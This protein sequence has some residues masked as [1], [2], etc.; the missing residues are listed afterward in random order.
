MVTWIDVHSLYTDTMLLY[1]RKWNIWGLGH[2]WETLW[3]AS[4]VYLGTSTLWQYCSW[5]CI[6]PIWAW[7]PA[8]QTHRKLKCLNRCSSISELFII[9][10]PFFLLIKKWTE[11]W[12]AG[13]LRKIPRFV[14][15]GDFLSN[16]ENKQQA[17]ATFPLF[18]STSSVA[19]F[20][21]HCR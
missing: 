2:L 16:A 21:T 17:S 7:K 4:H 9:Q 14:C 20:E 6:S 15:T 13:C 1:R 18:Q 8:L 12:T 3:Q 11:K 10:S 5:W 19:A